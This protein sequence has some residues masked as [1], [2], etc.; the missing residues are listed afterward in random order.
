[1]KPLIGKASGIGNYIVQS[2]G[3]VKYQAKTDD[4]A[5][6]ESAFQLRYIYALSK[7]TAFYLSYAFA[8]DYEDEYAEFSKRNLYTK[9]IKSKDHHSLF[10]KIRLHF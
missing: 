6:S 2:N 10:A 4:F 7:L 5:F 9:A 1:M 8:G 3:S